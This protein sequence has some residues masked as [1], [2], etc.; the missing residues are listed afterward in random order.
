MLILFEK[1]SKKSGAA[2]SRK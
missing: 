1:T 2:Q